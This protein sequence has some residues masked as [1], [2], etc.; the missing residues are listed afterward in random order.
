MKEERSFRVNHVAP[1]L[2]R[3]RHTVAFPIQ[4]RA[5]R[6]DAD[7]FLCM[8]GRFVALEL[9]KRGAEPRPHQQAKLDAVTRAHG[10]SFSANPDNWVQVKAWLTQL[11]QGEYHG[12]T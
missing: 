11:D 8:R 5:I 10:V 2:K 3:L 12:T 9:K 7:Y 1:F 4:Q 6:G